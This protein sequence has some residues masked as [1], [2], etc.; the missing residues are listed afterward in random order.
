ME[1]N[2]KE[3]FLL[4]LRKQG[5]MLLDAFVYTSPNLFVEDSALQQLKNAAS[6]PSTVHISATP[7]IHRDTASLS[8]QF[9]ERRTWSFQPP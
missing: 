7:D 6:I 2:Q 9:L 5:R 3:K 8:E 1:K 4:H